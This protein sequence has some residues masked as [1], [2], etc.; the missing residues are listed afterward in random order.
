MQ[1][2]D[3]GH[4]QKNNS[5]SQQNSYTTP[6]AAFD[7]C[8]TKTRQNIVILA[9]HPKTYSFDVNGDYTRWQ[10][11]FFEIGNW[12]SS[13]FTGMALLS[14]ESTKDAF[15]L[16]Q[17]GRLSPTYADKITR[18]SMDTMHDVGFLYSLY[19]VGLWKVTGSV[20]HR[21]N[22]LKAAEELAKRYVPNGQYIRAWGRMDDKKGEYA[23]LAIIDCMMNLPLL[24]WASEETGNAFFREIAIHHADTTLKN[25][26]RPDNSV[27][28][29]YRFDSETGKPAREDNYCGAAVGSHWARGTAWAIYGFALAYR[30]TQK[31]QY[32]DA[33]LRLAQKFAS[34]LDSEVVP[35]WDFRRETTIRDSSAASIAA[36]GLYELAK[37]SPAAT[38]LSSLADN[39]ISRLITNYLNIDRKVY[40]LLAR[41]EVGDGV[42]QAKEVYTSWGDYFFMEALA[43]KLYSHPTYW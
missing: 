20:E 37:H 32:L 31:Q 39:L 14:Y 40:G 41:G 36:C 34:L 11:G 38:E 19:S 1:L 5:S 22:G 12:T 18:A 2:L 15:F 9:N 23:G 6:T 10:E 30:Y 3:P 42:G 16:K 13:F 21:A 24:F 8:V 33:S 17:L 7:T 28:H 27:C 4:M 35:L 43:R 26:I 29:A 25:F